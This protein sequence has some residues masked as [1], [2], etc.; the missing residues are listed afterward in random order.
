[1]EHI[2]KLQPKYFEYIKYGT[3]KV[4]LRLNDEKRK[5]IKIG[6]KIIFK[7]EPELKEEIYAK[8]VGITK[9]RTFKELT[10]SLNICEYA[11]ISEN[12][13][14]FLQDLYKFYTKE[15][16][17]KYGVIGIEIELERV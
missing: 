7:K 10:D 12:E 5:N 6:D 2:M 13:E 4:E 17:E 15:Q 14:E 3:K 8:I 16:E 11:D 9:K 1:M